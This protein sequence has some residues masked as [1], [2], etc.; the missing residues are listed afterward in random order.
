MPERF[1]GVEGGEHALTSSDV[2]GHG[3][4]R[5]RTGE[6]LH[7]GRRHQCSGSEGKTT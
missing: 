7:D 2:L 6:R 3:W 1:S 4:H 5:E